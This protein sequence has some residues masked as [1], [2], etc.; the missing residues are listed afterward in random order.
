MAKQKQEKVAMPYVMKK[1]TLGKNNI[2]MFSIDEKQRRLIRTTNVKKLMSSLKS[3]K[4]FNSPF[5]VNAKNDT[6]KLIDGNH[7]YEAIKN[8]IAIIPDFLIDIWFAKYENLTEVEERDIFKIWNI[9]TRQTAD[10]FLKI[11]WKTIPKGNKMLKELNASIYNSNARVKIKHIVGNH[12][13]AKKQNK[14]AGGY[15]ACSEKTVGDFSEI[16]DSDIVVMKA[17][18]SDMIA[19]FGPVNTKDIYWKTTAPAAFY[20]IWYDNR[21]IPRVS[22]IKEFTKLF[23]SVAAG[24]VI[25]EQAKASGRSA[26]VLFYNVVMQQL[27]DI[28]KS[29]F[30]LK[31]ERE[32]QERKKKQ[33]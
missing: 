28:F 10:D 14:F 27:P 20:R 11:Y 19:I 25:R 16:T 15:G 22:F 4:H 23:L 26:T 18:L 9:G 31:T 1:I 3:G 30:D 29:D 33:K 2:S 12:I 7:R 8:V 5:V 21:I 13:D 6:L 24:N 32:E 17:Y